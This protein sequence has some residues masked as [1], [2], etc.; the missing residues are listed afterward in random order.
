MSQTQYAY[1]FEMLDFDTLT[2]RVE[3]EPIGLGGPDQE[4]DRYAIAECPAVAA[5]VSLVDDTPAMRVAVYDARAQE[6]DDEND[7]FEQ[8]GV[9]SESDARAA[10]TK[11]I[12]STS[13]E[14]CSS[15]PS[16]TS[17]SRA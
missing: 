8:N 10:W 6:C 2:E 16:V 12:D 4:Q 14:A 17:P 3:R 9:I 11:A 5:G 13:W 7:V 1:E 15:W